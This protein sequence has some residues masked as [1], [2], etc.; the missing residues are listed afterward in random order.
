VVYETLSKSSTAQ[1][2]INQVTVTAPTVTAFVEDS[3]SESSYGRIAQEFDTA[4]TTQGIA[5]DFG[6]YILTKY[7]YP[8]EQ[9][10]AI[11][12]KLEGQTLDGTGFPYGY[13]DVPLGAQ[14]R[15]EF[16]GTTY[17]VLVEGQQIN[18]N[19]SSGITDI[20]TMVSSRDFDSFFTFDDST[21]GR[22]DYNKI[23][24]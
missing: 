3:T 10:V 15:V 2:I 6:N 5:D 17:L 14:L 23:G 19:A 11:G 22:L 8:I 21:L 20:M 12:W 4:L 16:D 7:A 13:V 24:Y 18:A 9:I 1:T